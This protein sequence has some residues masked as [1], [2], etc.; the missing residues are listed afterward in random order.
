[1]SV[2]QTSWEVLCLGAIVDVIMAVT[3]VEGIRVEGPARKAMKAAAR[4]ATVV[5]VLVAGIM[6][7]MIMMAMVLDVIVTGV[8]TVTVMVVAMRRMVRRRTV[9]RRAIGVDLITR[10]DV[11]DRRSHRKGGKN[12]SNENFELHICLE[13]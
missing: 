11:V 1:M 7:M 5:D 10:S 8:V 12:E 3:M 2:P 6:M 13:Y 9:N 4:I